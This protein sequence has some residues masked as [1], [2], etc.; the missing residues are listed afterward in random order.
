MAKKLVRFM[1]TA[2]RDGFQ[3]VYGARVFTDDFMPAVE[4]AAAA[5][6]NYFEAGGGARF[7]ALYFYSNECAF[8]MMDRF[9][10]AAGP[11]ADLQTLAR[12]IN[13]VALDSQPKDMIKLHAQMFKKHGISTIRNFD[14][15]ND[16][17]NLIYSG[18]CIAEA[19]LNHQVVISMMAL[20]PG[21]TGAHD[22]DFYVDMLKQIMDAD[23]PYHSICFKDASG[24]SF[25]S[26]VYE[27][28]K[29]AK[30]II[31]ADIPVQFHT[32]DT[33]GIGVIGYKAAL[34]A[35]VDIIDLSM[36][37]CSGGTCQPDIM[38]MWHALRGT[39]YELDCDIDKIRE[40]EEVFKECMKDYFLPPEAKAVEPIIPWSPMPGGALTANSQMMRDNNIMDRFPEIIEAMDEVVRLGGF[41]TS[42]TPVSQ[43]YFQQAF[44]NVMMGKWKKIAEGYGKMVL[45]Y[46]GKTP[47]P[48][49]AEII[50]IASEQLGLEPTTRS[51]LDINEEDPNKGIPSAKKKLEENGL[52][53]TD[54]NIFIAGACGDK[55]INYLL[56][57]ATIGVRKNVAEAPKAE[58]KAAPDGYTV[59]VG[60]STYAV[61]IDGNTAV[62][63]GKA[64]NVNVAEG[65][66]AAPVAAAA[67]A[68]PG[69]K[70]AV[71]AQMPGAVVRI[72][73][74][75]GAQV[76][77]GDT[78]L[79]QEAMK[80]E[81]EVKAPVDGTVAD[82]LVA[83]GDQVTA[84]QVLIQ[85]ET[86]GAPAV[87]AAPAAA[88]APAPAPAAP[89]G[90]GEEVKAQMPGAVIKVL[91]GN[92]SAVKA[93][94]TLLV[95]EAMKMEVE[96]K[97]PVD[98]TVTSVAVSAGDQVASGQSLVTIA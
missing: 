86:A 46:F 13:V 83:T 64:Y 61:K 1:N 70:E 59:T 37:P 79:V 45:G 85:I 93:G 19:G 80:M 27:T 15:L 24:T 87:A 7:Q 60:G 33:A 67:P 29:R 4:A 39:E 43:F 22:A 31:P 63:N 98:G 8:D 47:V 88:A 52:P 11:D 2:F 28:I 35:G 12:G 76:K 74:A 44:N 3:S 20:P 14:A 58:A 40:A 95:Q 68:A 10:A 53:T 71:K 97:A 17:N 21:C 16:V 25:P 38:T 6:C 66:A 18:Q 26:T 69:V 32:H 34:D 81:V 54:E 65:L 50:K 51:P 48:P 9:R 62:V 73:A 89:A 77:A 30:E 78:L 75:K 5:G 90:A 91:V 56:G 92:G 42:V 23:I 72:S 49:D 84:D 41:G 36:A 94:D 55:G 57:K 96:V 82:I